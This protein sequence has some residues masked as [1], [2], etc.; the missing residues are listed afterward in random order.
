MPTRLPNI[1]ERPPRS[2]PT[3]MIDGLLEG[4][5]HAGFAADGLKQAPGGPRRNAIKMMREGRDA[6]QPSSRFSVV[7]L[8][9]NLWR[10]F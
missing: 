10:P 2:T 7:A 9:A 4:R 3:D 6:R 1:E 5:M 8:L